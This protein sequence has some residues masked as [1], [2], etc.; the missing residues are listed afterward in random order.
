MFTTGRR[1]IPAAVRLHA[2]ASPGGALP[3]LQEDAL[4]PQFHPSSFPPLGLT[5]PSVIFTIG[6]DHNQTDTGQPACDGLGRLRRRENEAGSGVSISL[7]LRSHF[8]LAST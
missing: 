8:S 7:N 2:T 3:P 4:S 6:R 1:P 5:Q